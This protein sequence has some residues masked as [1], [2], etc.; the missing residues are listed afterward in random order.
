MGESKVILKFLTAQGVGTP[1]S[2][3]VQRLAVVFKGIL[4]TLLAKGM[5]TVSQCDFNYIME[6]SFSRENK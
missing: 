5:K 6:I 1:K 4:T 2:S 3:I